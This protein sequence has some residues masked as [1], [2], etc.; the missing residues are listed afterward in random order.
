MEEIKKL[1]DIL[2]RKGKSSTSALLNYSD[3]ISLEAR[4]YQSIKDEEPQ[5][6]AF[7]IDK[8]YG[9][10]GKQGAYKMLKSRVKRKLYNQLLFL[11]TDNLKLVDEIG[12]IEIKCRKILYLADALRWVDEAILSE[13]QL[14]K[15]L[16]IAQDAQF[17]KYQIDGL[18]QLRTLLA[19]KKYN[20]KEFDE[21]TSRL[22]KLYRIQEIER[23]ADKRYFDIRFDIKLGVETN[24]KFQQK[25]LSYINELQDFWK[26][27]ESSQ[28]FKRYHQ[29]KVMYYEVVGDFNSSISYINSTFTLYNS[30]KVHRLYFSENFNRFLLVFAYLRTQQYK[31]GL[32]EAEKLK[33]NIENGTNNWFM[34]MENY[35]QLAVH[36]KSYPIAEELLTEVLMHK[37]YHELKYAAQERW[38]LFYRFLNYI[39]GYTTPVKKDLKYKHIPRDKKGYNVWNLILDFVLVLEKK[40][41]EL[42]ERE[43]DRVR[44]FITKYL[45]ATEDARTKLFLKLLLIAGREYPDVKACKRKG[46]YLF[47]KL[48]QTPAAGIAYAETEIMPF[49]HLWELILHKMGSNK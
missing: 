26:A 31:E 29:L 36:S 34:H 44:K 22:E 4:L 14:K 25:L 49:E 13:Q 20:R 3:N 7:L 23:E 8:L 21:C 16:T 15:V 46:S 6:E 12:G 5:D 43:I 19:E 27:S 10:P 40:Q 48:Q 17:V 9:K 39:T 41:P 42:I 37:Y 1:I 24:Y 28:V 45:G 30:G 2:E 32:V 11:D 38:Y 35:F 33:Y 18:E 47:N